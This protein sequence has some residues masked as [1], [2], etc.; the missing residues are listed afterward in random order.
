MI[1]EWIK[2]KDKGEE[3]CKEGI[4][5]EIKNNSMKKKCLKK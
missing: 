5:Q 4:E 2:K 1:K 3:I